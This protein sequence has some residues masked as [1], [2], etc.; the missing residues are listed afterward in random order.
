MAACSTTP[1]SPSV[2]YDVG[3]YSAGRADDVFIPHEWPEADLSAYYE[4]TE[5]SEL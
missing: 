3:D 2:V 5:E 1:I 4:D